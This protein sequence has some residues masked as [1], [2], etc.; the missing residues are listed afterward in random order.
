[1]FHEFERRENEDDTKD[2]H[3]GGEF[4][5]FFGEKQR[6]SRKQEDLALSL[7]MRND[8][9]EDLNVSSLVGEKEISTDEDGFIELPKGT[10]SIKLKLTTEKYIAFKKLSLL[11]YTHITPAE[12]DIH[13]TEATCTQAVGK[14]FL[15][16]IAAK[17][18]IWNAPPNWRMSSKTSIKMP[19]AKTATTKTFVPVATKNLTSPFFLA[20]FRNINMKKLF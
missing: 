18:F 11:S 9:K 13:V 6:N 17:R 15:A 7:F 20:I 16:S 1:M 2:R 19:L 8:K 3:F 12:K 14:T 5:C 10:S 4:C